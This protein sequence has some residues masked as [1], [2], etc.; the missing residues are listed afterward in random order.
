MKIEKN[1]MEIKFD[2]LSINEGFAR[3]VVASFALQL[4]PT[5]EE[6][7]DIKTA[8]SEA[9]TNCVVHAYPKQKGEVTITCHIVDDDIYIKIKDDGIGIE[10]VEKAKEPF[11]TS[12]PDQERSGMGFAVMESFMDGVDVQNNQDGAGLSVTMYKKIKNSQSEAVC[13]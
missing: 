11:Y 1:F 12:K 7:N 8:V 9:V 4:N 6:L 13:D 10:D 5:I 2:A 3:T